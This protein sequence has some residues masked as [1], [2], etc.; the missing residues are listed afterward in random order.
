[1]VRDDIVEGVLRPDSGLFGWLVLNIT[2]AFIYCERTKRH[3]FR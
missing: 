3:C 2:M 1:M